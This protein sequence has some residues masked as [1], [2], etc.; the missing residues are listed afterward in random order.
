MVDSTGG[1]VNELLVQMQSFDVPPLGERAWNRLLD[2]VN[3]YLTADRQLLRRP[4]QYNNILLIAATNR[5]Q[6]LDPALLRPG[7][8]DRAL[9]FD[10]PGR[11]GRRELI[12]HFLAGKA[13]HPELDDH[14]ARERL[15]HDTLG[16]TPVMI[17][18]LLD[19]AL[20]VALRD[21]RDGM[22][23]SDVYEAKLNEEI[24]LPQATA[25]TTEERGRVATH[26]AGHAVAAFLLGTTRRL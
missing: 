14:F 20:L 7:R 1:I 16:Y 9:T 25:Y 4:A 18:H 17:E 23:V 11:H 2:W 10:L 6:A 5:A 12:D 3:G 26:E 15:A 19:E 22:T 21:G 8:F 24:G 13:H